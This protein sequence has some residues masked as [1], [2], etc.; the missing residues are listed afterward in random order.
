MRLAIAWF[1]CAL[2]ANAAGIDGRW[3]AKP[4][5]HKKNASTKPAPTYVLDLKTQ[6][7]KVMGTV[8][9]D[10]GKKARPQTI[11]NGKVEGDKI[12]FSTHT[13][14]KKTNAT[15]QWIA[16]VNGDQLTGTRSKEGAKKGQAFTAKRAN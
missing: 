9:V 1:A 3:T 11:E 10:A 16:T 8:T 14:N 5:V 7:G 6:D 12:T 15:F 4:A 13:K 2:A